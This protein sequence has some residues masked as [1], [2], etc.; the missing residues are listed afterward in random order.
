MNLV[1]TLRARLERHP[2]LVDLALGSLATVA[3]VAVSLIQWGPTD[4]GWGRGV[5]LG[6]PLGALVVWTYRRRRRRE[7]RRERALLEQRLRLSRELHDSVAAHVAVVGVQA[8]A[9][10]RVLNT[11]PDAAALA[12]ERIEV[13]SRAAV[14]DLRRMLATLRD[15]GAASAAPAPGLDSIDELV[16]S[17]RTAGLSVASSIAGARPPDLSP[18]LDQAAYRIVQEALTNVLKHTP[19]SS[20]ALSIRYE[21]DAVAIHV[22]N[23]RAAGTSSSDGSGLGLVGMRERAALFGGSLTAGPASGR[24]WVVDARLPFGEPTVGTRTSVVDRAR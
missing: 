13:V 17:A 9:A 18:A 24:R 5:G 10:R 12:L 7:E 6:V 15:Q 19:G 21:R 1:A 4:A 20:V 8:A 14:A 3:V 2:D 16:G 22:E 11:Q 23:A